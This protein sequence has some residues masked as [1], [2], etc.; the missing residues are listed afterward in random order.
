MSEP[1]KY[2]INLNIKYD[3][4]ELIDIPKVVAACTDQW[5]NQTLTRVNSSV[6][7]V[8]IMQ[9]EFH[10]HKHDTDDEFFFVLDGHLLIDLNDRTIELKR[11]EGVTIT[12][13]LMHRPRAPEKTVVLLVEP[14]GIKPTGD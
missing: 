3:H 7:R 4:L 9:G 11:H 14:A 5:F 6:V 8:A 1:Q 13:G 12:R 2:S 10:G